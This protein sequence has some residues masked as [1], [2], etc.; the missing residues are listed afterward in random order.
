MSDQTFLFADLAGFTALTEHHGD[1]E[2]AELAVGFSE[3]CRELLDRHGATE[4]KTIGDAMLVRVECPASAIE[5]GVCIATDLGERHGFPMIRVGMHTGSAVERAG[6]WF[7]AAVNLAAR[8][9]AEASGGQVLLTEHT[10]AVAGRLEGIE[11]RERGKRTLRNVKEPVVLLEALHEGVKRENELP[12][13]PVCR[14]AVDP[15]HAA[16][17]LRHDGRL[18]HFC[19]L[20]CAGDFAAEPGRY[21]PK[22]EANR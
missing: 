8:V 6:D 10:S 7:G 13:D 22:P 5:L 11:L 4:V 17:S 19:S 1:L 3:A 18:F 16:G 21:A 9:S 12:V 15:E 14:M 20:D 2:A